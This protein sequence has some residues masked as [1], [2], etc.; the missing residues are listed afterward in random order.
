MDSHSFF[1]YIFCA[2][3][4]Y[5]D[6][7]KHIVAT[8]SLVRNNNNQVL[9]VKTEWRGW[10]VPGGQVEEGEDV[11]AALKR[12]VLEEAGVTIRIKKLAAFY[13]SVSQPSKVIIDFISEYEDGTVKPSNEVLGVQWFSKEEVIFIITSEPMKYRV[14]WLL[15]NNDKV[16]C[17]AYSKNPFHVMSENIL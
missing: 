7:P 12:E 4:T 5:M 2:S 9:L 11:I 10:E 6:Y 13:S 8:G 1:Y 16:R 17:A 15:E 14:K 3:L